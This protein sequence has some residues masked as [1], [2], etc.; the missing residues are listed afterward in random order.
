MIMYGIRNCDTCK[1]ALKWLAEEGIACEFHDF[2]KQGL[3]AQ[4]VARWLATI[5]RDILIN[6]RGT[7]YR[8]LDDAQKAELSGED[9]TELLL[10]LPTLMKRPIFETGD[11]YL[12]GFTEREKAA[13][14][15]SAA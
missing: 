11:A 15:E 12:V 5:D 2:R 4:T 6:K 7:T 14:K 8:Q 10:S 9:P 3:E 13:L 1:K